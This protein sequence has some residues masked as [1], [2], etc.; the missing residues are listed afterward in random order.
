MKSYQLDTEFGF[1]KYEGQTLDEIIKTDLDYINWC[2]INLDHFVISDE[3]VEVVK[4][5]QPAFQLTAEAEEK[6]KEKLETWE[7]NRSSYYD[8]SYDDYDAFEG[9]EW[10][11]LSRE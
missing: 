4:T 7:E 10:A 2:L 5:L 6:R 1:G 9:D 11:R 8:S 3:I